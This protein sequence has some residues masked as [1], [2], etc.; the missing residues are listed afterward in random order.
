MDDFSKKHTCLFH[1]QCMHFLSYS[2]QNILNSIV[3]SYDFEFGPFTPVFV[4]ILPPPTSNFF[5]YYLAIDLVSKNA[6]CCPGAL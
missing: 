1:A 5:H 2:W 4:Y 3:L 6:T